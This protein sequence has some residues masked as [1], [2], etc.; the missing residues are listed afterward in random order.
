MLDRV[1]AGAGCGLVGAVCVMRYLV[2]DR[3][4]KTD[5]FPLRDGEP[6]EKDEYRELCRSLQHR[7]LPVLP[8]FG[9]NGIVLAFGVN[10]ML[11]KTRSPYRACWCTSARRFTERMADMLERDI[12]VVFSAGPNFPFLL[13]RRKLKLYRHMPDGEIRRTGSV[14]A[15]YM[16]A[17]ALSDGWITVSSWGKE[18][19]VDQEEFL[20]YMKHVSAPFLS[21]LLYIKERQKKRP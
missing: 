11:R 1:S 6:M 16:I 15:H 18:Y 8:Y 12:P 13:G 7:Y 14:K 17:T 3:R 10:R 4:I 19:L 21:N 9:M 5:L 2:E 20:H